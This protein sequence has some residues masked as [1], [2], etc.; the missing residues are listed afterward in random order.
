MSSADRF[1]VTS[2]M[3]RGDDETLSSTRN[4]PQ[5]GVPAPDTDGRRRVDGYSPVAVAAFELLDREDSRPDSGLTRRP[6]L[7]RRPRRDAFGPRPC[8][9]GTI[10]GP[11]RCRGWP[12]TRCRARAVCPAAGFAE[13][14]LA[15]ACQALGACRGGRAGQRSR[16]SSDHWSW[17]RQTRVTT[18]LAQGD[19]GNRVEI[20]ASSAGGNWRRYAVADIDVTPRADSARPPQAGR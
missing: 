13:M 3:K 2:A 9:A 10:S 6:P 8:V 11:R 15:A 1:I 20:H 7:A 19:D 5:L 14:A 18:Q 17:T 4:S 16:R 12:I